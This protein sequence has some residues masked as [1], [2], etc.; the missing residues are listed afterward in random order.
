MVK[1]HTDQF[2]GAEATAFLRVAS[3]KGRPSLQLRKGLCASEVVLLF[4]F[5]YSFRNSRHAFLR[6]KG[7]RPLWE[8]SVVD[9]IL[10]FVLLGIILLLTLFE[11]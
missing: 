10:Y 1:M 11:N 6:Y 8:W 7:G 5:M 2:F 4:F 3:V 9:L